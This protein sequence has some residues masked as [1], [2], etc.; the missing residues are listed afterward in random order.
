MVVDADDLGQLAIHGPILRKGIELTPRRAE[1]LAMAQGSASS[2]E[3]RPRSQ[4]QHW[5]AAA[6]V[7]SAVLAVGL[8]DATY[9]FV[10]AM[11]LALLLPVGQRIVV[12]NGCAQRFGLRPVVLDLHTAEIVKRARRGGASCSS[13]PR[14]SCSRTPTGSGCTSSHGYG[15]PQR[16]TRALGRA[17]RGTGSRTARW[18]TEPL[19]GRLPSSRVPCCSCSCSCCCPTC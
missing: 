14:R 13:V 12:D 9:L 17:A 8:H 2:L 19:A 15:M 4:T 3:L 1:N 6:T 10:G 18:L 11:F 16:V 5:M 7:G